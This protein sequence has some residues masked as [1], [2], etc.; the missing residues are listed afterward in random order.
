MLL[1][2]KVMI[3]FRYI[4]WFIW[5]L[6][7][8]TLFFSVN[9]LYLLTIILCLWKGGLERKQENYN[10]TLTNSLKCWPHIL[11]VFRKLSHY[12]LNTQRFWGF[13]LHFMI[14]LIITT[15]SYLSALIWQSHISSY[16]ITYSNPK[17]FHR[18]E[19]CRSLWR[20][21]SMSD[22][23]LMCTKRQV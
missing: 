16:V 15:Y 8:V 9:T 18:A 4:V 14:Y 13:S 19:T 3:Q 12:R 23:G 1:K 7:L 20:H 22:G 6:L 10:W 2:T 5:L 11:P 21:H 17:S